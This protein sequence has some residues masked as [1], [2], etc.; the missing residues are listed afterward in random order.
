MP[1]SAVIHRSSTRAGLLVQVQ[2]DTS[3]ALCAA[4][5]GSQHLTPSKMAEGLGADA[6]FFQGFSSSPA[7]LSL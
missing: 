2:V 7:V 5:L 4:S 6:E 1:Q 3:S